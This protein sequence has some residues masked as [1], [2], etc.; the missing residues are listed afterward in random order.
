M[1]LSS[2]LYHVLVSDI[3]RCYAGS[4]GLRASLGSRMIVAS[5]IS[6]GTVLLFQIWSI[7]LCVI[8][9]VAFPP[10]F[11]ASDHMASGPGALSFAMPLTALLTSF[12]VGAVV[13]GW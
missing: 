6:A 4:F 2:T 7:R 11:R 12:I 9:I 10:A 3:G 8:S 1:I 13:G 5:P